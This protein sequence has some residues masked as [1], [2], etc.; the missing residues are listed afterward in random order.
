MKTT[1]KTETE[2][3]RKRNDLPAVCKSCCHRLA[4]V[5]IIKLAYSPLPF[6]ASSNMDA[7]PAIEIS[8]SPD[9]RLSQ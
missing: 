9:I 8:L 4:P 3:I 6:V 7:F 5:L 2:V 1:L